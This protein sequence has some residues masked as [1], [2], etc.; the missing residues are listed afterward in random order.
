MSIDGRTSPR[1]G[2]TNVPRS[3][4]VPPCGDSTNV[5]LP[6]SR[7][8]YKYLAGMVVVLMYYPWEV[9]VR[10]YHYHEVVVRMYHYL[11]GAIGINTYVDLSVSI[12]THKLAL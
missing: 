8:R 12:C 9:V 3:T 10:L 6:K 11:S 2:S 5:L 4:Y 1:G 7:R